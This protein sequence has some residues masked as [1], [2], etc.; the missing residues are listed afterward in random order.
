MKP[1]LLD[2]CVIIWSLAMAMIL[3]FDVVALRS[4]RLM[5]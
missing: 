1:G 5:Q 2:I 3:A 4:R